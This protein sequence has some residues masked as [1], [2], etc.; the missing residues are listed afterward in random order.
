MAWGFQGVEN[1][2]EISGDSVGSL[3]AGKSG[4]EVSQIISLFIKSVFDLSSRPA[5]G[6]VGFHVAAVLASVLAAVLM[7]KSWK[8]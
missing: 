1:K 2:F 6:G 7:K 4:E 5:M 8:L 3:S